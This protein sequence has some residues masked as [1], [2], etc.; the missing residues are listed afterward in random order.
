MTTDSSSRTEREHEPE[1]RAEARIKHTAVVIMVYGE[2]EN[3]KFEP[4]ELVDCSPSG[5]S[6]LFN[7]ALPIGGNFLLKIKAG[8][9][10]LVSYTVRSCA[11]AGRDFRIGGQF[12]QFVGGHEELPPEAAFKALLAS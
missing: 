3:L 2:G 8:R 4:A 9:P 6:I 12:V 5:I 11:P 1:R 7:R 10:M